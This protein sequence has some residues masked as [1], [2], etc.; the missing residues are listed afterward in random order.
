MLSHQDRPLILRR[1][2]RTGTTV[3]VGVP[4]GVARDDDDGGKPEDTVAVGSADA[5][6]EA[7]ID[8]RYGAALW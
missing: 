1:S 4:E 6:G 3:G 8:G 5:D 2:C 7:E